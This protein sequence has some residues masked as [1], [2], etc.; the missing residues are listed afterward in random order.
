MSEA[1]DKKKDQVRIN[2]SL[3]FLSSCPFEAPTDCYSFS[4]PE[5]TGCLR[6]NNLMIICDGCVPLRPWCKMDKYL[7]SGCC[8]SSNVT[9]VRSPQCCLHPGLALGL[10]QTSGLDFPAYLLGVL[11]G[12][13]ERQKKKDCVNL[14]SLCK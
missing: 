13:D 5:I 4:G 2:S 1:T 9:P 12:S 6:A 8:P 3:A 7:S 11:V 10:G 14:K